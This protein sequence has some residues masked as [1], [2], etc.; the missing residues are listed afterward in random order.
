M[1]S[2]CTPLHVFDVRYAIVPISLLPKYERMDVLR[3]TAKC[4]HKE[5]WD[6]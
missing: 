4:A 5:L 3:C 2:T 6:H 1:S